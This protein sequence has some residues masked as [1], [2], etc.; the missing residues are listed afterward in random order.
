MWRWAGLMAGAI[1]AAG[2]GAVAADAPRLAL[3]IGN[4]AYAALPPLG[5]CRASA[6]VVSAALK[7][8]GFDVTERRDLSNGAMGAA[9]TEFGDAIARQPGSVAVAY[10]C[11]YAV[12]FDGRVFLLPVSAN[13]ERATDTL[14]QGM[15]SRTSEQQRAGLGRRGRPGA[16]GQR[17]PARAHGGIAA[18]HDD[19]PGRAGHHRASSPP[20]APRRCRTARRRSPRRWSPASPHRRS[21]RGRC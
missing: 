15:V 20:T 18:R 2:G 5:A 16:A 9:I 8:A 7:R 21:K 11:G 12:A 6:S 13:L 1:V 14:T 4:S 10:A 17:R 19:Q 3:V